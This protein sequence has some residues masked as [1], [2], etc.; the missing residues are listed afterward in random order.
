MRI[1]SSPPAMYSALRTM[2]IGQ[3]AMA[4]AAQ[5]AA[6][7]GVNVLAENALAMMNAQRTHRVGVNLA[8]IADEVMQSTIDMIA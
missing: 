3:D 1:E 7:G 6:S 8:R 4:E 2:Q 5:Q